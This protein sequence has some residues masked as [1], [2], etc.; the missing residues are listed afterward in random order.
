MIK[1][2]DNYGL[3]EVGGPGVSF[4]CELREG[5]HINE[6]YFYPEI[7]D[8]VSGDVLET[9]REGELVLTTLTKEAFPIG[10]SE[11]EELEK[12]ISKELLDRLAL[13]IGVKLVLP[14]SIMVPEG[15]QRVI[16]ER[17]V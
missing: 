13:E 12:M 9:G 8:P 1:A 2:L 7:I 11:R 4:E 14:G 5:L 16:D 6:D 15:K 3:A 10:A 17:E